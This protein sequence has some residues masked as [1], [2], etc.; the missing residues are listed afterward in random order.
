MIDLYLPNNTYKSGGMS[1]VRSNYKLFR[2]SYRNCKITV[3]LSEEEGTGNM[4]NVF[5]AKRKN[6]VSDHVANL[7]R[8]SFRDI[9]N[10]K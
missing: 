4:W 7:S 2:I 10:E 8:I 5:Y 9:V 3:S 6:K 1:F